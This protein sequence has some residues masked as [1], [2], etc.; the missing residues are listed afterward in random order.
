MTV[1]LIGV[2]VSFPQTTTNLCGTDER[3]VTRQAGDTWKEDCNRCRCTE[4]LI[5]GCTKRFCGAF[6]SSTAKPSPSSTLA[7]RLGAVM[8]PGDSRGDPEPVT[9]T[10]T[11]SSGA[12]REVGESWKEECNS[13]SCG[14]RGLA[15]C[16]QR[17]CINPDEFRKEKYLFTVDSSRSTEGIIQCQ[18]EGAKNCVVVQLNSQYLRSARDSQFVKLFSGSDVEMRVTRGPADLTSPRLSYIFS[19]TDGGEGSLTINQSTSA[20]YASFKPITGSVH[21][22]I[23]YCGEGCGNVMYERDSDYFNQFQD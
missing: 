23:E 16:T 15:V 6:P 11:D 18:S 20:A 10:C 5:P 1:C 13:C 12:R 19:L 4:R 22:N 9:V 17:F 21:Y 7:T 8:F 3:G 14:D 2:V